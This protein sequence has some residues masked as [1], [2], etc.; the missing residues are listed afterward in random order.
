MVLSEKLLCRN[1]V[2]V[3]CM[4]QPQWRA[5]GTIHKILQQH[6]LTQHPLPYLPYQGNLVR[7]LPQNAA[8]GV[9]TGFLQLDSATGMR[10]KSGYCAVW[11]LPTE[12]FINLLSPPASY[13]KQKP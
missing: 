4:L 12:I 10:I 2:C 9:N 5:E 13:D 3:S 11:A 7:Q 6:T 8:F 1:H